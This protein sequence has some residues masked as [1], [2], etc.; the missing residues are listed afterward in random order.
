MSYEKKQLAMASLALKFAEEGVRN[1][2]RGVAE[3]M[4]DA[5]VSEV[6]DIVATVELALAVLEEAREN[7]ERAKRYYELHKGE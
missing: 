7:V 3:L 4:K 5:E 2:V 1:T 6:M